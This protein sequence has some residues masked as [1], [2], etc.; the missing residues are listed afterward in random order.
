MILPDPGP[1]FFWRQTA[2]GPTLVCRALEAAAP[3]LFTTRDWP[4]GQR[5]ASGEED[6][7]AWVD[8]AD[9][10]GLKPS[11][12]ARAHQ[13]HGAAVAMAQRHHISAALPR[14][15]ILIADDARGC[16]IQTADCVP[17]LIADPHSGIVGAGHAGWRGLVQRVPQVAVEA[18]VSA[19][20]AHAADL[21]AAIGPAIGPCCYEVGDDVRDAFAAGGFGRQQVEQWFL[22]QVGATVRNPPLPQ[23]PPVARPGRSYF[24]TWRATRDQLLAAGVR[25]DRIYAS[26]LFTA[27]HAAAFCSYRRDG[28]GAGRM[29]AA[30]RARAR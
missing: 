26:E 17:L 12:L 5:A 30:I 25:P 28:T 18:L 19:A 6:Q 15:D 16:A 3:H 10:M 20:G 11:D 27:S 7:T 4:L 1:D 2:H 22:P 29:A 8:V 13:V 23:L 9:A 21:I 24:D 14:A